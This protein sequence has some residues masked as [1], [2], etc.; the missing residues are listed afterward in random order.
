MGVKARSP[1]YALKKSSKQRQT[2]VTSKIL[3]STVCGR[4]HPQGLNLTYYWF[5]DHIGFPSSFPVVI[6]Q[7]LRL[8][9][10]C[11]MRMTSKPHCHTWIQQLVPPS[12]LWEIAACAGCKMILVPLVPSMLSS[13]VSTLNWNRRK[14]GH[15]IIGIFHWCLTTRRNI[16]WKWT[17]KKW[18][19][20]LKFSMTACPGMEQPMKKSQHLEDFKGPPQPLQPSKFERNH[21][22]HHSSKGNEHIPRHLVVHMNP[23]DQC[24]RWTIQDGRKSHEGI[25]KSWSGE[26]IPWTS[27]MFLIFLNE[28][29]HQKDR[30]LKGKIQSELVGG[31]NPSEKY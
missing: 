1:L 5:L 6:L 18:G 16:C 22:V 27:R 20:H 11:M 10:H 25:Q 23:Y 30:C 31:L 17:P 13:M 26:E 29:S 21:A 12:P 3:S 4:S 24:G 7:Y 9:I 8:S 28:P 15:G 2:Y 19:T 14:T